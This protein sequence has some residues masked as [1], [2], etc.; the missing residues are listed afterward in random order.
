M[1]NNIHESAPLPNIESRKQLDAPGYAQERPIPLDRA[2]I[3]VVEDHPA[4]ADML[5]WT[6]EL[7]GYHIFIVESTSTWIEHILHCGTQPPALVLLD[8]SIPLTERAE[9]LRQAALLRQKHIPL[10]ILTTYQDKEEMLT[11]YPVILKPFHVHDLLTAIQQALQT[12]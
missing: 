6:L 8:L 12:Y 4:I 1:A 3:L 11:S 10:I 5:R 2:R 7:S 9:L